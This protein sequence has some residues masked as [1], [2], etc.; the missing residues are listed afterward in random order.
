MSWT[1]EEIDKVFNEAAGKQ[2]FDYKAEYWKEMEAML[3]KEKSKDFLWF[4]TSILF[5]GMIGFMPFL[6]SNKSLN[7]TAKLSSDLATNN[8]SPKVETVSSK[9]AQNSNQFTGNE[10]QIDEL[11][12]EAVTSNAIEKNATEN[13][14]ENK[15][16]LNKNKVSNNSLFGQSELPLPNGVED[17]NQNEAKESLVGNEHFDINGELETL[18]VETILTESSLQARDFSFSN[19]VRTSFYIQGIAG[20]S[21]SLI[22]PSD[23][24]SNNYG[25][26]L[27]VEFNKPRISFILG[28]NTL[29]SNHKDLELNRVA[30]VYGFGSETFNYNID[31]KSIYNI[32]G[33]IDLAYNIRKHQLRLGLRPSYSFS[34]KVRF[35]KMQL[36][37]VNSFKNEERSDIY[38]FMEG[39][40]RIGLKPTIGYSFR[41]NN[42]MAFGVNS[43]IQLMKLVNEDFI[44]GVNNK[45][46]IDCQV[47]LRKSIQIRK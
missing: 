19:L 33:V 41:L 6:N 39:I 44:N 13:G 5:V 29:V 25:I 14:A 15:L 28:M 8:T 10:S 35:S 18:T 26:G 3:P 34:S 32:E 27:G 36:D 7:T 21:Q 38:G 47:Y 23:N 24:I 20:L 30:K 16:T 31:Y 9:E 11:N 40:N 37:V 2:V 45:L 42:G 12:K 4:F 1:D 22:T 43:G 46:P 17:I